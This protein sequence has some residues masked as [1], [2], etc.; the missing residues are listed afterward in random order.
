[1]K[2]K[3]NNI[4]K[5]YPWLILGFFFVVL[6]FLNACYLDHWLDSDMAA[7]MMF[8][9]L[10]AEEG[11]IFATTNWYYSTEFR[12]LYTH[13]LMGPLFRITDN[14][15]VI[16]MLTNIVFY[17]LML[18]SY[19]YMV[20]PLCMNESKKVLC[21]I[22]LLLPFSE[23]VM[24][25]MHMGN[26]YMSHV[27]II[28]FEMGIFLRLSAE[29]NC[30]KWLWIP[31]MLLAVICGLSG[32]RYM[33]ALQCP[34]LLTAVTYWMKSDKFRAF[35]MAFI[36]DESVEASETNKDRLTVF[37][38]F[39]KDNCKWTEQSFRYIVVSIL[40]LIGTLIGY[41]INV[42]YVSKAYSFQTY[43]T[44][45]FIHVYEGVF[46][47]RLQN[48]FGAILMLFGYIPDKSVL[49]LRG[50]V[51]LAAFGMML[52]LAIVAWRVRKTEHTENRFIVCFFYISFFLNTFVF[53][54]TSSTLVP[55]YYITSFVFLIPM[56]AIYLSEEKL[57]LDRYLLAGV[58]T[59]CIL[60]GTAKT[61]LSMM[62]TDKN[63]A[64]RPVA[65]FLMENGYH[66]GYAT[67]WNGNI[68]QEL[69]DGKI[70][71]ANV[72]DPEELEFFK[73]SSETAYYEDTFARGKTFLLLT[74][75]EMTKYE[76]SQ[77]VKSGEVVYE[78]DAFTI[79][80]YDSKDILF[81]VE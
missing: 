36:N 67:Y 68:M 23:N 48:A 42:V 51:S 31:Y 69:S 56:F 66:Q 21:A 10:L 15:H 28:L 5:I 64:R 61:S 17:V 62:A 80:H 27:I 34:L 43:E 24:L 57:L 2:E 38:T 41:V 29:G 74:A 71:M 47:E 20:K 63:E 50:V 35:R 9:K 8:S 45:N 44:T 37:K 72:S 6:L 12:F 73:W 26:T 19:F 25:H 70:Q 30:K 3:Y 46:M 14:W 52:V 11:S 33:L 79:L 18:A 58:M 77:A 53:V 49:S 60:L 78:S 4:Q 1:M 54:F 65:E 22:A 55:R 39:W 16:R 7:E 75:E 81:G 13:L 32:V 76:N 40:G 59:V